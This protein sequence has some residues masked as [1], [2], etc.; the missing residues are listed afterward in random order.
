MSL[1]PFWNILE[2]TLQKI[3]K[4]HLFQEYYNL[5]YTHYTNTKIHKRFIV[6]SAFDFLQLIK[7]LPNQHLYELSNNQLDRIICVRIVRS[8]YFGIGF[9]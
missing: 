9:R 6:I 2:I 5:K 3:E 4:N 7:I 1:I 8:S